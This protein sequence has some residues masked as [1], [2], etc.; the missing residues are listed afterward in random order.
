[1][2]KSRIVV[3]L[4]L[5]PLVLGFPDAS[6]ACSLGPRLFEVAGSAEAIVLARIEAVDAP[7]KPD[8]SADHF[9]EAVVT[10]RVL[11]TWKGPS[12]A[13]VRMQVHDTSPYRAGDVM[14]AFL[15]RGE[16]RAALVEQVVD[17]W[18]TDDPEELAQREEVRETNRRFTAWSAGR[19]F[20]AGSVSAAVAS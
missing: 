7:S 12:M 15:E 14:L 10:L 5:V 20:S 3:V 8:E 19:W 6:P 2:K 18:D 4:V 17:E 11:E 1:M 9:E 13:E 16:T